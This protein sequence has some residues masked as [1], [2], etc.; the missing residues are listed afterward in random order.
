MINISIFNKNN[1]SPV[2]PSWIIRVLAFT[3]LGY[4]T[5]ISFSIRDSLKFLRNSLFKIAFLIRFF[6]LKVISN[7][8]IFAKSEMIVEQFKILKL[9]FIFLENFDRYVGGHVHL[10]NYTIFSFIEQLSIIHI[11]IT[12]F[13]ETTF[14][15]P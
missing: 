2:S 10:T 11:R 3:F 9:L 5:E 13:D 14:T 6:V 8:N 7:V 15:T 4:I 12:M 1:Y